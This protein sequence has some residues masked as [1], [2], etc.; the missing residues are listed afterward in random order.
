MGGEEGDDDPV[1]LDESGNVVT[2]GEL[3]AREEE[4]QSIGK[5]D[6]AV[7]EVEDDEA[8]KETQAAEDRPRAKTAEGGVSSGFA[9][10]R[11]AV[12]VVG[13]ADGDQATMKDA[14]EEVRNGSLKSLQASTKDLEDVVAQQKDDAKKEVADS[15]MKKGKKKKIKLSFDEPE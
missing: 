2:K 6:E 12:K 8:K 14:D 9:R 3:E 10:K 15:N 4:K 5:E 1:M 13:D 7:R 11:K